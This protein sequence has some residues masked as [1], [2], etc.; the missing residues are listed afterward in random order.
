MTRLRRSTECE[1]WS[2]RSS[3][4][5]RSPGAGDADERRRRARSCGA[6]AVDTPLDH[7]AGIRRKFRSAGLTIPPTTS[8]QRALHRRGDRSRLRDR[9]G[10]RGRVHHR[11]DDAAGG[12][13]R[14]APFAEKHQMAVAMH[15]HS[16]LDDPNEFATPESFAAAL[17]LSKLLQG[18]PRHRP[19]HG[20]QLRR[21]RVHPGAPRAHH[22]PALEGPQDATRATTRRGARATR[23]SARCCSCSRREVADHSRSSSTAWRRTARSWRSS[24]VRTTRRRRWR[25]AL[26]CWVVWSLAC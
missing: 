8:L 2:P 14:V 26:G 4:R 10:A 17:A 24:A 16:N 6:G 3:R 21:R 23:R 18:Q 20:R 13:E 12:A 19:L 25:R 1:L 9:Q 22:Q 15:N 7:F 11:L 5:R